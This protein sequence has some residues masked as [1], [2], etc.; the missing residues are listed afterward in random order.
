MTIAFLISALLAAAPAA[1][2]PAGSEPDVWAL[3]DKV[4][5]PTAY[6]IYLRRFPLGAH[7]DAAVEAQ[8]RL[9][10][11]TAAQALA[12]A[13]VAAFVPPYPDACSNLLINQELGQIESPEARALIAAR[14]GN[15][16]ADFRAFLAVYPKG[17]C[18][19]EAAARIKAR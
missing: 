7:R 13:P 14:R 16:P 5:T 15:R 6:E 11:G 10:G 4:G 8:A 12:P 2:P 17:V 9:R 19:A 3:V 1:A 18:S